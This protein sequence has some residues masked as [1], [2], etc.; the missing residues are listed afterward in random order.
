MRVRYIVKVYLDNF[1]KEES[2]VSLDTVNELII[3]CIVTAVKVH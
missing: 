1:L 2:P 3:G